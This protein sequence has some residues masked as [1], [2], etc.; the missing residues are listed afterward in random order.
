MIKIDILY[1]YNIYFFDFSNKIINSMSLLN[2]IYCS[3]EEK[4]LLAVFFLLRF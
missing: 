4:K 2:Q 1:N 3:D